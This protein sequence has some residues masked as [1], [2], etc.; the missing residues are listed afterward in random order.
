MISLSG[1]LIGV[2]SV[3]SMMALFKSLI[4][5]LL[6][7]PFMDISAAAVL[8]A[9]VIGMGSALGT[10]VLAALCSSRQIARKEPY[11]VIRENE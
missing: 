9:A 8:P 7:I 3:W 6:D 1:G 11:R 10:G 5:Q 2:L 4:G